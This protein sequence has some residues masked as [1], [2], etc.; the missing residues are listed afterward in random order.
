MNRKLS[1]F[2]IVSFLSVQMFSTL[3]MAGHG[4]EKHEHNGQV[5]NVYLHCE[6]SKLG[7]PP[8]AA[9]LPMP[10]HFTF[11]VLLPKLPLIGLVSY[12]TSLARA[13]PLFS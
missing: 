13:P 10:E 6:H 4:F 12:D 2:L 5:C 3:H 8:A 1:L 11:T 9:V 7:A